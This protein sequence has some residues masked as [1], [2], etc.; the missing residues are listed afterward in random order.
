VYNSP[1]AKRK[2]KMH[3]IKT[4]AT[5]TACAHGLHNWVVDYR[6]YVALE[7]L[8]ETNMK[9]A[10]NK[11]A[12]ASA[13]QGFSSRQRAYIHQGKYSY[14]GVISEGAGPHTI[15]HFG[16]QA[17][18]RTTGGRRMGG[19][20]PARSGTGCRRM[21]IKRSPATAKDTLDL[22]QTLRRW[23]SREAILRTG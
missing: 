15:S 2:R 4:H 16:D 11:T 12:S 6:K 18:A 3:R 20:K 5:P 19:K 21:L 17:T 8:W 13:R 14:C 22:E 10:G 7:Q 9:I 23:C 1:F